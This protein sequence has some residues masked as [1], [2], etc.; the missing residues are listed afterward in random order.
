MDCADSEKNINSKYR[1]ISYSDS[2]FFL[3][4]NS[5]DD[6]PLG[7]V[8]IQQPEPQARPGPTPCAVW[9]IRALSFGF[10]ICLIGIFETLFFF[11]FISKSEDAGIQTT[12]QN[13]IQ[14]I[15]TQCTHWNANETL[16]VNQILLALVNTTRVQEDAIVAG[17]ERGDFNRQLEIQAWMYVVGMAGCILVGGISARFVHIRIPVRRILLENL[18]MVALLG[19]YELM[20]FKTIIYRY[21][22][23]T[24]E[25]L[26]GHIIGQLQGTCGV[27]T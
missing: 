5:T 14:G 17:V 2:F 12:I 13:Y 21:R 1:R 11:L 4:Q 24:F 18:S 19:L 22:S 7:H 9:T 8:L 3:P 6:S 15:L 20:F 10:H 25:E 27:G 23:L 26:N 16:V